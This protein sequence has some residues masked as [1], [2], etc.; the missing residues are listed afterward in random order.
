MKRA[1]FS[2][3]C[4]VLCALPVAGDERVQVGK[5]IIVGA[6]ETVGDAVCIGCSVQS[7]GNITGDAVAIGG[8]VEVQ[9]PVSGDAVA[10]GG[11]LTLGPAANVGG[12]AVS[13]GGRL[14]RDDQAR[15][16]GEA[17]SQPGIARM[18][19]GLVAFFLFGMVACAIG[20]IILALL[21]YA[22]AGERRLQTIAET[23]RQRGG[24]A[25]LVGLAALV[26]TFVLFFIASLIGPA[27]PFM[28]T[29]VCI[30][31]VVTLVV[32]YAG[33]STWVG[34]SLAPTASPLA[35]LLLGAVIIIILQAIPLLNLLTFPI[36]SLLALGSAILS[37][38]GN[39]PDW[40][41]RQFLTPSQ[42]APPPAAP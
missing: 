36:F 23:V 25:F 6:G 35:V 4:A 41:S 33:L 2:V 27:T 29:A 1:V 17:V 40:M 14:A 19:K 22:I 8:N 24:I 37:G 39:A 28:A 10:I 38:F 12:D 42:T 3:L 32:G 7:Q 13:I 31:L 20:S 21:C 30:L 18:G 26:S 9:G 11:N 15:V 5:D 16:G 34:R